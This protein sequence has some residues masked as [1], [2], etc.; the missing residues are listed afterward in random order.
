MV[1]KDLAS[2]QPS[3]YLPWQGKVEWQGPN[4]PPPKPF[5]PSS[6]T[7]SLQARIQAAQYAHLPLCSF[8]PDWVIDTCDALF[9]RQLREAGH[10]LWTA[11]PSQPDLA[12]RP[13]DLAEEATLQEQH[14]NTQVL[15]WG[16]GGEGRQAGGEA[17]GLLDS[18]LAPAAC[19]LCVCPPG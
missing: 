5:P 11:D 16:Q 10:V 8:G 1:V 2:L 13:P 6:L 9:A 7:A 4:L 19:C 17:S 3:Q 12:T 14:K 18:L 15:G